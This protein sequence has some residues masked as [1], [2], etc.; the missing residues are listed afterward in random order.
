MQ[1]ILYSTDQPDTDNDQFADCLT[2]RGFLLT[3]PSR[4][5]TDGF[6]AARFTR[7]A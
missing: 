4:H 1:F 6:F 2:P 5:G 7:T 3:L